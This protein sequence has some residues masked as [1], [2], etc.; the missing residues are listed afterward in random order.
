MNKS[1]KG[2]T[3]VEFVK[4]TEMLIHPQGHIPHH[5]IMHQSEEKDNIPPSPSTRE[6]KPMSS[7]F[8]YQRATLSRLTHPQD[9]KIAFRED[10]HKYTID[11]Y[12]GPPLVSV[13]GL[14]HSFEEPFDT[15]K[16]IEGMKLKPGWG[17]PNSKAYG[18][19]CGMSNQDII[20]KWA[21]DATDASD[22]GREMH[23]QIETFYNKQIDE[24][25]SE[26]ESLCEVERMA[27][28][29]G[30]EMKHFRHFYH[31]HH[32]KR[33]LTAYKSEWMVFNGK[34]GVTGSIDMVYL[35]QSDPLCFLL[36]SETGVADIFPRD[37]LDV[38]ASFMGRRKV[39]VYDWKRTKDIKDSGF[40]KRLKHP[41]SHWESC[42]FV[43]YTLQLNLY[44]RMLESQYGCDVLGM[45]M[46]V[47][48]PNN[49]NYQAWRI[50]RRTREIDDVLKVREEQIRSSSL[51]G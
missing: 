42:N 21:A 32:I 23:A 1:C 51:N 20:D 17:N 48:H 15:H 22:K 33:K 18:K 12:S 35:D 6:V 50:E 38:V 2:R 3:L 7:E 34:L 36:K 29:G 47:L 27:N 9:G 40:G 24:E 8:V 14:L 44:S 49:P 28:E 10:T 43:I 46:V 4:Q 13:T 41:L 11:G 45:V 5:F 39:W 31:D 26:S 19:Y 16:S 30:P 37:I 25:W